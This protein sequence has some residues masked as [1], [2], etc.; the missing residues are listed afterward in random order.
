MSIE[1]EISGRIPELNDPSS[2]REARTFLTKLGGA[3]A[4]KQE[5]VFCGVVDADTGMH[6]ERQPQC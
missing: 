3:D 2:F 1:A 5:L 6:H 4:L